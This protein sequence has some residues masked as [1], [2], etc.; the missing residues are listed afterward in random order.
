MST[1]RPLGN[2]ILFTFLDATSGSAGKF[3]ERTRGGLIIPQLQSTQKGERWGKVTH[4]G[5]D[6][7]GIAVGEFILIEPM[8]WTTHEVFE[9]EK[10]WKTNDT[11][12]MA[13][14]DDESLTVTW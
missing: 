1:L 14:T 9:G 2:T 10:V 3:T 8:M 11:K 6:V 5:P 12:V 13:V 7:E 4:I